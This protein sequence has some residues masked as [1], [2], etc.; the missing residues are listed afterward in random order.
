MNCSVHLLQSRP[1]WRVAVRKRI[2]Y[3]GTG[4]VTSRIQR[5][6]LHCVLFVACIPAV[7]VGRIT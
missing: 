5:P 2:T 3:N 4:N 7:S 1:T 6:L